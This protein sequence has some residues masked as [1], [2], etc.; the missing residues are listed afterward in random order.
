MSGT[1][2]TDVGRLLLPPEGEVLLTYDR[3]AEWGDVNAIRHELARRG[4]ELP[5]GIGVCEFVCRKLVPTRA[6][7]YGARPAGWGG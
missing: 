2:Y 3:S 5:S 7:A 1:S 6:N 4:L